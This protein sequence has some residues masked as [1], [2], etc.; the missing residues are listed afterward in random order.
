VIF[1]IG[2]DIVRTDRLRSAV[3][4]WGERLLKRVFTDRE[5]SYAYQK[6]DPFLSLAARFA[7]KEALIKAIGKRCAVAF[8]DIEIINSETGDPSIRPR[9]NLRTYFENENVRHAH[10]SLSHEDD[11]SIAFVIVEK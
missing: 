6:K 7:A 4:R 11:Y 3:E 10:V 2:T 9:G 5:I 1:G 8:S